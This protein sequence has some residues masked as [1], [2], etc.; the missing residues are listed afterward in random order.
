VAPEKHFEDVVGEIETF[1][2]LFVVGHHVGA[3]AVGVVAAAILEVVALQGRGAI[4]WRRQFSPKYSF[5]PGP[6]M[7]IIDLR[8]SAS[9]LNIVSA[10]YSSPLWSKLS[11]HATQQHR[12]SK[13][14]SISN[15]EITY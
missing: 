1:L 6:E 7:Q 13:Q 10:S 14:N 15:F 11:Q 2:L 3:V 8:V 9:V 4:A 5:V 12:K